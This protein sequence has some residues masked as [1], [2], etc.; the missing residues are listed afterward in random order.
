MA[1]RRMFAKSVIESDAFLDLPTAAADGDP[2]PASLKNEKT[3]DMK[4]KT[5]RKPVYALDSPYYKAAKWLADRIETR[6]PSYKKHTDATLQGWADSARLMFEA[7]K[8]DKRLANELLIFS[9]ADDFWKKNILSMP[10]FRLQFDK[11]NVQYQE[12]RGQS[13]SP[14]GDTTTTG[15]VM[16][17]DLIKEDGDSL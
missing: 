6:I 3:P 2:P 5:K 11:L 7:D 12:R 8:R 1:E 15:Y 13:A 17:A 16:L 4:K 9:Q 14:D 10:K